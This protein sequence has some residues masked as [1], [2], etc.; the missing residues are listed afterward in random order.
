MTM[1]LH[2]INQAALV[3]STDNSGNSCNMRAGIL[4]I[5]SDPLRL[6]SG[7]SSATGVYPTSRKISLTN[8]RLISPA[9]AISPKY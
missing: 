4:I 7:K 6:V 3:K 5:E 8:A 1:L 2:A 9:R